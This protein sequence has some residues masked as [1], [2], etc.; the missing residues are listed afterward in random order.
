MLEGR[1]DAKNDLNGA[2][3]D[4]ATP[5][6]PA[7]TSRTTRRDRSRVPPACPVSCRNTRVLAVVSCTNSK[8]WPT[9]RGTNAD[10]N[11]RTAVCGAAQYGVT[12]GKR[13]SERWVFYV[14]RGHRNMTRVPGL[15]SLRAVTTL[16]RPVQSGMTDRR[17]GSSPPR[18][19][20]G[21]RVGRRRCAP[22]GKRSVGKIQP[23]TCSSAKRWANAQEGGE[24]RDLTI[25]PGP[26]SLGDWPACRPPARPGHGLGRDPTNPDRMDRL[27]PVRCPVRAG[28]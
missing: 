22:E 13:A 16:P 11:W 3:T 10:H 4:T 5:T 14:L 15:V 1:D 6:A 17:R 25:W 20:K 23:G 19:N 24:S 8:V 2:H 28:G 21:V 26:G 27:V 7:L 18:S 12:G 9:P